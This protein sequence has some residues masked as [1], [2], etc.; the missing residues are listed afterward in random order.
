MEPAVIHVK[1]RRVPREGKGAWEGRRHG[2]PQAPPRR[3]SVLSPPH[4]ATTH[5]SPTPCSAMPLPREGKGVGA[6]EGK[7]GAASRRHSPEPP[8]TRLPTPPHANTRRGKEGEEGR[9]GGGG[10]RGREAPWPRTAAHHARRGN[11]GKE[12]WRGDGG[13]R[14]VSVGRGRQAEGGRQEQ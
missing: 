3:S 11:E 1:R 6:R 5:C 13:G 9:F 2:R 8:C 14:K 10:G 4:P 7:G 12:G